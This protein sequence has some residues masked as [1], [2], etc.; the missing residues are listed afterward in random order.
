MVL[1]VSTRADIQAAK[2]WFNEIMLPSRSLRL[3][4]VLAFGTGTVF[5]GEGSSWRTCKLQLFLLL[6]VDPL[7][8]GSS[9]SPVGSGFVSLQYVPVS[10]F[11]YTMGNVHRFAMF[12]HA[13]PSF[14]SGYYMMDRHCWSEC[15]H[16]V[17]FTLALIRNGV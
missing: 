6:G 7:A 16:V 1:T 13:Q 12:T 11:L 17:S 8:G 4:G 9:H 10:T 14:T 2:R 3:P 5:G 15:G